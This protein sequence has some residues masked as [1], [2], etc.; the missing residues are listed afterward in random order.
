MLLSRSGCHVRLLW[1][2]G[3][4]LAVAVRETAALDN[5]QLRTPPMGF[6]DACLGGAENTRLG[7]T[8]MQAVAANFLSSGLAGSS[9]TGQPPGCCSP[10]HESSKFIRV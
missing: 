7:A 1:L 8:Q 5:G 10:T 2:V 3:Q 9:S 4:L 6:S